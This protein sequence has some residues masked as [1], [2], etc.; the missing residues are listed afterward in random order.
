MSRAACFLRTAIP[1]LLLAVAGQQEEVITPTPALND[2]S[3]TC[4]SSCAELQV[5]LGQ[6]Y[7][8]LERS[9]AEAASCGRGRSSEQTPESKTVPE[10]PDG[11]GKLLRFPFGIGDMKALKEVAR[12]LW[13]PDGT[14]ASIEDE[15]TDR[16]FAQQRN[17]RC[18][19]EM[20]GVHPVG[21]P[22]LRWSAQLWADAQDWC[23]AQA[24]CTGIML[25]VG[26]HT[27]NCHYW[28]ARPQFCAGPIAQAEDVE[29]SEE[30]NLFIK[31][32]AADSEDGGVTA[33]DDV[34][35]PDGQDINSETVN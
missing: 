26:K 2:G 10:W 21:G 1:A 14:A 27:M 25:Y 11:F 34:P 31:L 5:G 19:S 3:S 20:V 23:S 24:N 29:P 13:Q 8:E 30:W 9:R 35:S 16:G 33:A 15:V 18:G 12:A 6:C 28:C 32:P 4:A 7:A 22:G 17:A